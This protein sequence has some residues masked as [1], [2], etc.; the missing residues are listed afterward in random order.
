M[1]DRSLNDT[2][3]IETLKEAGSIHEEKLATEA[4]AQPKR[5]QPPP[6]SDKDSPRFCEDSES[7]SDL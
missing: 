6:R 5:R 7:D 1:R 3:F 2:E 4:A